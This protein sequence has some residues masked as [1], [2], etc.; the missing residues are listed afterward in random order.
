VFFDPRGGTH[1]DGR[2][3][4][5]RDARDRP[6]TGGKVEDALRPRDARDRPEAGGKVRDTLPPEEGDGEDCGTS[7]PSEL[8]DLVAALV[9]ENRRRGVWPDG[10]TA[11]SRWKREADLPDHLYFRGLEA[12]LRG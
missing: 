6:E 3:R 11:G 10:W 9:E 7:P 12:I 1:F 2:W 4:W 8:G 5:P